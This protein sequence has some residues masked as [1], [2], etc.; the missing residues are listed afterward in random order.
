MNEPIRRVSVS[1]ASTHLCTDKKHFS[2]EYQVPSTGD[3]AMAIPE[4]CQTVGFP[5]I[6]GIEI[7]S[8]ES[9]S[10]EI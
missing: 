6:A 3:M 1:T 9:R 7:E 5:V 10:E 8:V 4:E 2:S